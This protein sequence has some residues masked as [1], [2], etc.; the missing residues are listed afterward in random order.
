MALQ[1][2]NFDE[3]A[4]RVDTDI[5]TE[6]PGLNP[7][8]RETVI[9]A[10]A[11]AY[12]ARIYEV[13]L[14]LGRLEAEIFPHTATEESLERW[15]ALKGVVRLAATAATGNLIATGVNGALVPGDTKF[16][17]TSGISLKSTAAAN[18]MDT[19]LGITSIITIGAL[20]TVT[21]DGPHNLTSGVPVT[22]TGAT[23]P[24]YN[25]SAITVNVTS[26]DTFKFDVTGSPADEPASAALLSVTIGIVPVVAENPGAGHNLPLNTSLT[27][28][29]S[30]ANVSAA[31]LV[32]YDGILGGA[33]DESDDSFRGRIVDVYANPVSNFNVAAIDKVA[34]GIGG[35]TRVFISEITPE[36]GDVTAYVLRDDDDPLIDRDAALESVRDAI[37]GI[38]PAHMG[39]DNVIISAPAII[40]TTFTFDAISPNTLALRDQ[41]ET[42]LA[43]FFRSR[44]AVGENVT[45][46]GYRA[47]IYKTIALASGEEVESFSL[48]SPSADIVIAAGEIAGF[49]GVVWNVS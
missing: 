29:A 7:Q 17:T 39:P 2:P 38:T 6:L 28:G 25:V 35:V 9:H 30:I 49:G 22:I 21:T 41:I 8:V 11:R 1:L 36:V 32:P 23:A 13:Y 18:V 48:T 4:R 31:A 33:D 42:N 12:S 16:T 27:L 40:T 43:H 44:T 10:I 24:E 47:A 46:D 20:A 15:G 5:Q 19:V 45:A 37:A 3:V 34:R 26:K 14:T